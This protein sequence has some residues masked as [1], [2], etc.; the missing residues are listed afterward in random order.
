MKSLAQIESVLRGVRP[1]DVTGSTLDQLRSINAALK[2]LLS[3]D[4]ACTCTCDDC[5][6]GDCAECDDLTVQV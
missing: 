2:G 5:V 6:A 1:A 4:A 3:K